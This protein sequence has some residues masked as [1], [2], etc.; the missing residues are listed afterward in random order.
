MKI[1]ELRFKNLNSLYGSWSIDFKDP[2]YDAGGIFALTGPT[3]AG[4]STILDAICLALYGATPRLG[5][6]TKGGNDI[7]SRHAGECFA[8]VVFES[9]S[10]RYRCHWEQRRARKKPGE[11]LQTQK[12]EIADADSGKIIEDQIKKVS[13]V[14]EEKT[15]LDFDRFTRSVLL[16]QGDFDAFLKAETIQ[17]S[18]VLEQITGTE[19]YS[20][21]SRRVHEQLKDVKDKL[22]NHEARSAEGDL[23]SPD[24]IR[25]L[26]LRLS[27]H[28]QA[29][30][31]CKHGQKSLEEK[32]RWLVTT[33]DL[34]NQIAQFELESEALSVE[35][36]AHE[37]DARRLS[38][39]QKASFLDLPYSEIKSLREEQL[40]DQAKRDELKQ[41]IPSC[42]QQAEKS[43]KAMQ[44]A[45]SE[46]DALK[47]Q[48]KRKKPVFQ[49]A[50][51]LDQDLKS[52][53]AQLS[54]CQR[55]IKENLEQREAIEAK[56]TSCKKKLE[57]IHQ[58]TQK[59]QKYLLEH[60]GI[61]RLENGGLTE[62]KN[63]VAEL[64]VNRA[65]KAES[66]ALLRDAKNDLPA[67]DRDIQGHRE[68]IQELE[69]KQQSLGSRISESE[70]Y[71]KRELN[72]RLLREYQSEKEAR[73]RE[74]A[75]LSKIASLEHHRSQLVQGEDCPLCGSK[76]HPYATG[77]APEP[78]DS[79]LKIEKLTT[80]I[81]RVEAL[82]QEI[83]EAN[84]LLNQNQLCLSAAQTACEKALGAKKNQ[85]T[86]IDHLTQALQL[87]TETC[88]SACQKLHH[89][90][91]PF[92]MSPEPWSDLPGHLDHL[93]QRLQQ[94][95]QSKKLVESF[96]ESVRKADEELSHFDGS[97]DSLNHSVLSLKDREA[98]ILKVVAELNDKR[99]E[100]L[101]EGSPD[102]L[103]AALM[104]ELEASEN[105]ATMAREEK[106]KAEQ[107]LRVLE[108]KVQD[109]ES[110]I[111]QRSEALQDKE[112]SL[113]VNLRKQGFSSEPDYLKARLS[114]E[115]LNELQTRQHDLKK[116]RIDLDARINDRRLQLQ[117]ECDKQLTSESRSHLEGLLKETREKRD[118]LMAELA[119]IEARLEQNQALL[120]KEKAIQDELVRLRREVRK[121]DQLHQLIGSA[122]GTK[123]RNF[124]QGLTFELMIA[125]ANIQL[126]KMSDRYQLVRDTQAPLDLNV[127]DHYQAG[128][129]RPVK[130]LSG[131]ESF[132][133]SLSLALGLSKMAS[134]KVKVDSLFLDEGFGTLDEDSLETALETLAGLQQDGK[135]IGVISH[136]PALKERI[137]TQ[138]SVIPESAGR[139]R[140]TGP[141]C[142]F[143]H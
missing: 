29:D 48:L 31:A 30:E 27:E 93:E 139:S 77:Q 11:K 37:G 136:I 101:G 67:L 80:L 100:L 116:K 97:L 24:D 62:L 49:A 99:V 6:V 10:G 72:G 82:N 120:A 88:D 22:R 107:S 16:A 34:R 57:T 55:D 130:N 122:D 131:G 53:R 78:D 47:V 64:D 35:M 95:L 59:A 1:L 3:G 63:R 5:K 85:E 61:E 113:E 2:S 19:I 13:A 42:E 73:L 60:S 75:L 140:M 17:K 84:D 71:K 108:S 52:R 54:A 137:G 129:I 90:L 70:N 86:K 56:K 112:Q 92:G 123:Y 111:E 125:Y 96:Q 127:I 89:T 32:I 134:R 45:E 115:Q 110:V 109:L 87:A 117:T 7:M 105:K 40:K 66:E 65:K 21:I 106:S 135:L 38:L 81:G 9:E 143:V 15:G 118:L 4:K 58:E 91:S 25:D 28:K 74:L 26:E 104:T 94:W 119:R 8:E 126:A 124:A 79:E 20:K 46:T 50:R 44:N 51:N 43:R 39:A 83:S 132:L 142:Q 138:I 69:G 14:I 68:L 121:W 114:E 103:E 76:D 18:R 12:H 133:I 141:G 33:E 102:E 98:T 128:D 23:L 36:T 41:T